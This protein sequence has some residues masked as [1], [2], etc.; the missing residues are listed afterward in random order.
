MDNYDYSMD[1]E[2]AMMQFFGDRAYHIASGFG[3]KR[4][5]KDWL[6]KA[7][8]KM[9]KD[10]QRL[11]TTIRHKEMLFMNL[12][13]IEEFL[14][15]DRPWLV[16]VE[17]F[18]LCSRFLGYDYVRGAKYHIPTYSQN[19]SQYIRSLATKNK[20]FSIFREDKKIKDKIISNQRKIVKALRKQK[21]DTFHIALI[22]NTSEYRIKNLLKS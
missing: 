4:Y 8:R 6:K 17:L 14:K 15:N 20:D 16:I 22:L 21:L 2:H 10:V 19:Y 3:N 12:E 11:D 13:Q 1:F 7:A 9:M 5:M 18:Y